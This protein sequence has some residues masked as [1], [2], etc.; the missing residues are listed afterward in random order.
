MR[1]LYINHYAG[2][3]RHGM[4]YRPHYLARHWVRNGNDVTVVAASVSH[5]RSTAPDISSDIAEETIEGVRYIWLKTPGYTGNGLRRALNMAAFV[6][7]LYRMRGKLV[8]RFAPEAVIA[9]STYTW[10]IF[11]ARAIARKSGARL[12]YEVHD[13][14]PLSPMELGGMPRWHPFIVSLQRGEDYA[15]RHADLVVSMLPFADMHLCERGMIGQKFHYIPNGIELDEWKQ[16]MRNLPQ[17]HQ[18]VL[19]ACRRQGR[20][21]VGYAGAHG[22]ANALDGVLNAARI[23]AGQPVDFVLVGQGPHKEGLRQ[24]AREMQLHNLH[25][26]DPVPKQA[27]PALLQSMDALYIGLKRQP[28]FRF[29]ISPNKLMDYMASG[30]P[31]INAIDAPNDCVREARCGFSVRPEDARALADAV[32][33]LMRLTAYQR[34]QMGQRGQAY[35]HA[36][37]D[38]AVL[39]R[40]F[41]GLL[42]GEEASHA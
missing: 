4:E 9:S 24:K 33:R 12:V 1:I 13:L 17:P 10:D 8:E 31:I 16:D 22:L 6:M 21:I 5:V 23:M 38:Y 7:R 25:F 2:S 40:K 19:N 3:P 32:S 42:Q 37:H 14:W 28:V 15:C 30:K 36:H 39:A 26:L 35:V 11:P 27:I 34:L 18:D 20:F 29:G 41:L